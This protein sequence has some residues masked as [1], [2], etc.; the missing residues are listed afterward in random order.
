[1][2]TFL[3]WKKEVHKLCPKSF[4]EW[5][6]KNNCLPICWYNL[7]FYYRDE[8]E[9]AE[10]VDEDAEKPDGWLDDEESL[11]PDPDAEKPDD[12]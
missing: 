12:W 11:I 3:N 5:T 1:M 6:N 4:T 2:I 8:N 9:P 10:I 7:Y